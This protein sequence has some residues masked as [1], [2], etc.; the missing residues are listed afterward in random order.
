MQHH[1]KRQLNRHAW[2]VCL[3]H[4]HP[5]PRR[6]R[7]QQ[8][9]SH[10]Q[11]VTDLQDADRDKDMQNTYGAGSIRRPKQEGQSRPDAGNSTHVYMWKVVYDMSCMHACM[12]G[13]TDVCMYVCMYAC[14][15]ACMYG[16]TDVCMNVCVCV[17]TYM[18]VCVYIY[19]L[20]LQREM[21]RRGWC[22]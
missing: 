15:Y 19:I 18:Y 10:H 20:T 11:P 21:F 1:T 22:H 16:Y 12:Y 14:T 6:P 4:A 3:F 7:P 5:G 17:N 2:V 9:R 13:C 8:R